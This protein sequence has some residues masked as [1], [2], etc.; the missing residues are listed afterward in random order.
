MADSLRWERPFCWGLAAVVRPELHPSRSPAQEAGPSSTQ[1]RQAAS[2]PDENSLQARYEAFLAAEGSL[3]VPTDPGLA[4]LQV[5]FDER[6]QL[7]QQ[8]FTP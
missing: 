2:S 6:E 4:S 7:R 1:A 3:T 8:S 5:L